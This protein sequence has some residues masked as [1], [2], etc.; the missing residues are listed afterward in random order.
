M[1]CYMG[2]E[3]LGIQDSQPE[4]KLRKSSYILVYD[5]GHHHRY[6]S[7]F[8]RM[9]ATSGLGDISL[10]HRVNADFRQRCGIRQKVQTSFNNQHLSILFT[11]AMYFVQNYDF[12]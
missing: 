7:S 9:S 5:I 11:N 2:V 4:E 10:S 3:S 1:A 6:L 8:I 12:Q